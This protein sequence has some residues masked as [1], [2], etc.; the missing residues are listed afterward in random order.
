MGKPGK[1]FCVAS[2]G[3]GMTGR[4][5]ERKGFVGLSSRPDLESVEP[6]LLLLDHT[7]Q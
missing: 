3:L 2:G 1:W 7:V 5:G 4:R 6:D